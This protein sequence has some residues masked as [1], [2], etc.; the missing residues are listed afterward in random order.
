MERYSRLDEPAGSEREPIFNAPW[1]AVAVAA[2]IVGGYFLQSLV[3]QDALL[4]RWGYSPVLSRGRPETLLSAVFLHGGWAHALMNAAF[5]LAFATPVAR[6]F[7]TSLRGFVAFM[8][9]YLACGGLGNLAFGLLHPREI[10]PLIGAS[11]AVSG[12]AA[13]ASR[14]V[15]GRGQVGPLLSA[16]VLGMGGGWI[17]A[18]LLIAVVGFAPGAGGAQ[19]AWEVH[20]AG[21]AIGLFLLRPLAPVAGPPRAD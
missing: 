14:L 17:I 4:M 5:G 6:Y 19:V 2:V 7:G 21:F 3:P 15:A 11:G 10:A 20:L 8:L 16:P 9:F 13:A 18:N 1:P 12:L